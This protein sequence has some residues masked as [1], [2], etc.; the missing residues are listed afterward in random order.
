LAQFEAAR[1]EAGY[2]PRWSRCALS[3]KFL[4]QAGAMPPAPVLPAR[5]A[6]VLP[7]SDGPVDRLL[8]GYREYLVSGA[9]GSD[10]GARR[11]RHASR[12]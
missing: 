12:I 8:A 6:P 3:V 4:R 1:L 7:A 11:H 5:A 9:A 2:T 10:R